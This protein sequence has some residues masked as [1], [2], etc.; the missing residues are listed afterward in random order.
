MNDFEYDVK[1]KKKL[2][3]QAKHRKGNRKKCNLSTD[4]MTNKQWLERCGQTVTYNYNKPISWK[5]F[6]GLPTRVQK[7]YLLGLI[8]QYHTTA[9]DLAKMFGIAPQVVTKHCGAAEIGIRFSP[10]KRMPKESREAFDKFCNIDKAPDEEQTVVAKKV[11]QDEP[12]AGD[13]VEN[14][15]V[16][17]EPKEMNMTDFTLSFSGEFNREKVFNAIAFMVPKGTPV[18][19]DIKCSFAR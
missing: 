10:G 9:S 12:V 17:E 6:C 15:V 13:D 16:V 14:R 11:A 3:Y 8:D 7:E 5:G 19:I 18:K 1:E 4:H 2:A